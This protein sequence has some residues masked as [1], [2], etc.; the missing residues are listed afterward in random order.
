MKTESVLKVIEQFNAWVSLLTDIRLKGQ[1]GIC[2][3]KSEDT[4]SKGFALLVDLAT[5]FEPLVKV[6]EGKD[7]ELLK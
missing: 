6:T 5:I 1:C 2:K 3:T 7:V 4:L